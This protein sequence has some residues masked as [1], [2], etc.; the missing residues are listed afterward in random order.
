MADDSRDLSGSKASAETAAER[1][2]RIAKSWE[3]TEEHKEE[4]LLKAQFP[5]TPDAAG[6]RCAVVGCPK[7]RGISYYKPLCFAHWRLFDRFEI[8]ECERC[9]WFEDDV[10]VVAIMGLDDI[11]GLSLCYECFDRRRRGF[12]PAP[13]HRQPADHC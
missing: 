2:A 4:R 6:K 11:N 3:E 12:P 10:S 13:W 9:H 5:K 1:S 7:T 8:E